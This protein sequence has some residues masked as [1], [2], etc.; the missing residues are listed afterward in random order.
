MKTL[1]MDREEIVKRLRWIFS[2]S[3]NVK[4]MNDLQNKG[5]VADEAI[6]IADVADRDLIRVYQRSLN[7]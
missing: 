4:L 7:I 3:D 6:D 2:A 1:V 5:W